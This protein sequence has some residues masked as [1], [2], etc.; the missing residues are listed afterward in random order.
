M[1]AKLR[2]SPFVGDDNVIIEIPEKTTVIVFGKCQDDYLMVQ[3]GNFVGFVNS[4]CFKGQDFSTIIVK[5]PYYSEK[6]LYVI[7]EIEND[8]G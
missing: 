8:W 7:D 4:V 2:S 1:V 3:Y 5:I 6:M